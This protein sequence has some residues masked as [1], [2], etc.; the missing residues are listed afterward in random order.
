MAETE[1][2][3]DLPTGG[4]RFVWFAG[5][6]LIALHIVVLVALGVFAVSSDSVSARR[7]A[8]EVPAQPELIIATE[9]AYELEPGPRTTGNLDITMVNEGEIFH[10]LLIEG[11]RGFVLEAQPG[12]RS[13][14]LVELVDGTH[15]LFCSVPGHRS[16]GMEATLTV[17]G[18]T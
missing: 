17:A 10:N 14:G 3:A 12:E 11:Q 18:G 15:V 5:G 7:A 8:D 13:S 2:V 9:F 16:A 6:F 1:T 4:E